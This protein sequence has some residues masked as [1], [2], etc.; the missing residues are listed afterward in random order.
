MQTR[1]KALYEEYL[2][3]VKEG[4]S[5]NFEVSKERKI[6]LMR[7]TLSIELGGEFVNTE[8][9]KSAS[10]FPTFYALD[11]VKFGLQRD[12][13]GAIRL[14]ELLLAENCEGDPQATM[15]VELQKS[16]K[17]YLLENNSKYHDAM[18]QTGPINSS[19]IYH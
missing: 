15:P 7:D 9:G 5:D 10:T 12:L 13:P 2:E 4:G 6:A 19:I 3:A 1:V 14:G 16:V 17:Q 18:K 8:Y 11:L